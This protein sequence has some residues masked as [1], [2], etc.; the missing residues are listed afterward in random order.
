MNLFGTAAQG[1]KWMQQCCGRPLV[2]LGVGGLI[3]SLLLGVLGVGL[4]DLLQT[5]TVRAVPELC[6][7]VAVQ[8]A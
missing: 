6:P 7:T 1:A 5:N 2:Q 4:Q 8:P 3:V